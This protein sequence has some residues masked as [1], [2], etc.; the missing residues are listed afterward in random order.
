VT[1]STHNLSYHMPVK[2]ISLEGTLGM[3]YDLVGSPFLSWFSFS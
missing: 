1:K 2:E 3:I